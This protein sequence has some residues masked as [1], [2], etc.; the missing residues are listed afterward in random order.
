MLKAIFFPGKQVQHSDGEIKNT[1]HL[2]T[3]SH[4]RCP[5]QFHLTVGSR[6]VHL[7]NLLLFYS[8]AGGDLLD[9]RCSQDGWHRTVVCIIGVLQLQ[10]P[11]CTAF[12][13]LVLDSHNAFFIKHDWKDS[14][15][16]SASCVWDGPMTWG[17]E[18]L[19]HS[20]IKMYI[21]RRNSAP[22]HILVRLIC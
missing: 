16:A 19:L 3:V 21:K 8:W 13:S 18:V 20:T 17:N 15:A 9:A 1:D 6:T 4:L 2:Q 12:A 7:A 10:L 11:G 22:L 5:G 14:P